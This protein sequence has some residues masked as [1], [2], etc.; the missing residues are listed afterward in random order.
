MNNPLNNGCINK[1]DRNN[2][3]HDE[4]LTKLNEIYTVL[5]LRIDYKKTKDL[6]RVAM[7]SLNYDACE[8]LAQIISDGDITVCNQV[9]HIAAPQKQEHP[10]TYMKRW[11]FVAY[12]LRNFRI[13][14]WNDELTK[15][16]GK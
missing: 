13:K 16:Q 10:I 5:K 12:V 14:L 1:F 4:A 8:L 6:R 9:P 7:A 3:T 11:N 15:M 2:L